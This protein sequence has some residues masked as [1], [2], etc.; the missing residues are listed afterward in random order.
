MCVEHVSRHVERRVLDCISCCLFRGVEL[1]CECNLDSAGERILFDEEALSPK[2]DAS[3]GELRFF[4]EFEIQAKR[5]APCSQSDTT[6]A[7]LDIVVAR[8]DSLDRVG[9]AC[10]FHRDAVPR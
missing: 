9:R 1:A 4:I 8:S 3:L 6:D 5:P 2:I 10:C 7:L